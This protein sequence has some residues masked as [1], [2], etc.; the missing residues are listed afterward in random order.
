MTDTALPAFAA[1]IMLALAAS[2]ALTAC[3]TTATSSP[4]ITG[5]D[6]SASG[7]AWLALGTEPY[8]SI[9][10]TPVHITYNAPDGRRIRIANPGAVEATAGSS[11][12]TRRIS[13]T[14]RRQP[15][16][17][18][19]SDRRYR[20]TVQ[21]VVDGRSLNGCGGPVLP[22][23][24]LDGTNWRIISIDGQPV[25]ADRPA[26][27]RFEGNRVSGS[28]GCN[29]LTGSFASDGTRLTV[30]QVA[31]TRM[32]CPEPLMSQESRLAQLLGQSLAM[33]ADG[34]GRLILTGNDGAAII[35]EQII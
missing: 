24:H 31:M 14:A 12:T 30:A 19:M 21:A 9:E 4:A 1:P 28:A 26:E 8:W 5:A 34:R 17:D 22:P 27:L 7:E 11:Y 6:S 32:A 25:T 18:G 23:T 13:I 3:Q 2:F 15:C 20:D 29:R 35:L 33:R 10:V 16:N